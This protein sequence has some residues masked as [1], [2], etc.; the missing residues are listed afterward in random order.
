MRVAGS[1]PLDSRTEEIL[2]AWQKRW[3]SEGTDWAGT[4]VNSRYEVI[5]GL[6]AEVAEAAT[7]PR[8]P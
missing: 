4:L 7:R 1:S 2:R 8:Q 6:S 5:G 3:E